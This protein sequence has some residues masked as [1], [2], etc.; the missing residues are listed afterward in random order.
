MTAPAFHGLFIGIDRC[1]SPL[2]SWLTCAKRDAEA[3]H[4]LFADTLGETAAVL[5]TDENATRAAIGEQFEHRLRT[6]GECP[7]S[8]LARLRSWPSPI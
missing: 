5:L 4:A 1:A 7:S 3:L 6:V 8:R 2:I